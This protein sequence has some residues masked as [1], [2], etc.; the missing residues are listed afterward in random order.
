MPVNKTEFLLEKIA[1]KNKIIYV[2]IKNSAC[3]YI[4]ISYAWINIVAYI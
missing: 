3:N 4:T 1:D 2:S